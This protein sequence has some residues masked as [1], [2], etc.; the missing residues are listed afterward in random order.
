[1]PNI[2][3]NAKIVLADEILEDKMLIYDEKIIDIV[4]DI[5]LSDK[6]DVTIIDAKGHYVSAGF[7]DMHI[8]GSGGVDV[9]DGTRASL[10]TLSTTLLSTGTTSFLATT[11]SMETTVIQQ[12]LDTIGMHAKNVTGAH[13][14]G[15]H[16]EGPFLNP[17]RH[18]AQDKAHLQEPTLDWLKPYMDEIKMITLAP[19][20]VGAKAF[21]KALHRDYPHIILSAGH[22]EIGYEEALQSFKWGISHVTHLFNAMPAY[23]HR[24]PGLIG[25]VLHADVSCDMIADLVHSHASTLQMVHTLKKEK[26]MLITDAMRAGCMQCGRYELGGASVEVA[27][28]RAT[29]HDGTLAGS[30]LKMNEAVHNMRTQTNISLCEALLAVTRSPARK[31]NLP[32]GELKVGYDADIVIFDDTLQIIKTIVMGKERYTCSDF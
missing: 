31:L 7:I 28:G 17:T 8:H 6:D 5:I 11:M 25:A 20:I 18:G 27:N 3:I 14:L 24:N 21:I 15:V 10:E 19:E 26:F 30:V 22:T 4:D 2:I 29:L 9:M 12:A 23:H 1:M 32:K 16:L 13:I